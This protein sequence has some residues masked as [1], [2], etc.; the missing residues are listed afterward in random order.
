LDVTTPQAPTVEAAPSRTFHFVAL[1]L[2]ALHLLA[3]S[4]VGLRPEVVIADAVLVGHP[5]VG[6]RALSL[7]K[8]LLP[9]WLTA[10]VVDGQRYLPL[11]GK[12]HTG[13]MH[14]LELS[15]FPGP[16]GVTWAEFLNAHPHT[17][18]DFFCGA[19]YALFLYEFFALV[20]F[21][22]FVK[23][24]KVAPLVWAF[25][26]ANTIGAVVYMFCPVAPPWY[27][28]EHGLGPAILNAAPGMGGCAR[29]DALLHI[30]YFAAFYGKNPN[31]F[32]AMPSLH[33]SYPLLC[34]LFTWHKG[35]KWRVPTILFDALVVFSA[36]YLAHHW[37]LDVIAGLGVGVV[38]YYLGCW[39]ARA[40]GLQ[41]LPGRSTASAR[42]DGDRGTAG[43]SGEV[44]P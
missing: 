39:M 14:A 22:F 33:V 8:A 12:I 43:V 3:I 28:I 11:L 37:I 18:L 44:T 31:V 32:G 20:L 34:V 29:F 15:L 13:D 16:G 40:L 24:D 38:S 9:V 41:Q 25:F 35:W 7:T 23:R 27:I 26:W 19:S 6:P 2:G 17:I 1:A 36:V 21:F 4:F 30:H 5:W 42:S 10:V